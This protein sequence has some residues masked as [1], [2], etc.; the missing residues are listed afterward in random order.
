[1]A[2]DAVVIGP[3][4]EPS[5]RPVDDRC[6]TSAPPSGLPRAALPLGR[7]SEVGAVTEKLHKLAALRLLSDGLGKLE[8]QHQ[9]RIERG[10]N[11]ADV[12]REIAQAAL[13]GVVAFFL[14][15][16]IE[17]QPLVRLLGGL[18]ALS[19]GSSPPAM[20]TPIPTRHRRPDAP[21]I[22]GTKGRLAAIME[23]RQQAGLTRK[24]A[25]E[26]VARHI[27]SKSKRQLGP[28]TP[29]TVDS[30]FAKWGGDRGTT[31]GGGRDG[32]LH[33]RAILADKRPTEQQLKKIFEVLPRSLPS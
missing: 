13:T 18:E 20:F 7:C 31:P 21:S 4:S 2:G 26:W 10:D 30:W 15:H 19:A 24:A 22:E 12:D 33:M 32:Y 11:P 17:S 3:V 5:A 16:G 27:S 6:R 8:K 25:G 14:D 9:P 29:A 1:V 28:V 23:F